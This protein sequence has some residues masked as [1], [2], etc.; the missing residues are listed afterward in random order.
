MGR[1]SRLHLAV[2]G[3]ATG[4]GWMLGLLVLPVLVWALLELGAFLALNRR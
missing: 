4:V 3:V 2:L 1:K